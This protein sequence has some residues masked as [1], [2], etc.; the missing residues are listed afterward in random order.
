M[1]FFEPLLLRSLHSVDFSHSSS[2]APIDMHPGLVDTLFPFEHQKDYISM[3]QKRNGLTRQRAE[4]FVRLWAYLLLKQEEETKGEPLSAGLSR[5][6]PPKGFVPCTHREAAE[7]FYGNKERGSDRAAGMMIDR[8]SAL[9]LI[10][11]QYDGQVLALQ[12]QSLPELELPDVEPYVQV[13]PD[14]FNPRTDA[15]PVTNLYARSYAELIRDSSVMAKIA[16]ALRT[17]SRQYP[18]G[19]RVLRR[20][21]NLNAIAASVLYPVSSDCE[22]YFFQPPS[23]SF[24]LQNDTPED[25]FKLAIPGDLDCTSIYVRAWMIDPVYFNGTTLYQLLDDTR[26]TLTKMQSDFPEICDLYSLI[27]HP[28]YEELRRV[29]GFEQICQDTQRPYSWAYLSIDR[30]LEIDLKQA[31]SNLKISDAS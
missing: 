18:L 22:F 4:Y 27:V 19:M 20:S 9:G 16:R 24:Y 31:L 17:W 3:F 6:Y 12:I 13:F 11:K 15:I 25:P 28:L 10:E 26:M 8:L 14:A 1:D 30:F 2:E 23:K 5:L 29:L 7:L 21:D